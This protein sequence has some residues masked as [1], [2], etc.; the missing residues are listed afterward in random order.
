MTMDLVARII[1]AHRSGNQ[2]LLEDLQS[3]YRSGELIRPSPM[4]VRVVP[5]S[6]RNLSPARGSPRPRLIGIAPSAKA[7]LGQWAGD[8]TEDG[9]W[10]HGYIAGDAVLIDYATGPG[11]E[12]Q[13]S[14][15]S[16]RLDFDY[17]QQMEEVLGCPVVGD[18]H[19]HGPGGIGMPSRADRR[20]WA[21]MLEALETPAYCSVIME[22]RGIHGHPKAFVTYRN[23]GRATTLPA[24]LVEEI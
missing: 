19:T 3:Q 7:R 22:E 18:W 9:G 16:I 6:T 1:E 4:P 21:G 17:A 24:R 14:S 13:R 8:G 11:P 2:A 10:L 20:S 15:G 5:M 23:N 12:S